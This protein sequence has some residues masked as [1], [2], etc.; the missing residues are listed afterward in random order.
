MENLNWLATTLF[1]TMV[2]IPIGVLLI[3]LQRNIWKRP[4]L[5]RRFHAVQLVRRKSLQVT[6]AHRELEWA[7]AKKSALAERVKRA[8]QALSGEAAQHGPDFS[9]VEVLIFGSVAVA[10]YI[11]ECLL[12]SWLNATFQIF[13]LSTLWWF[14]GPI[15]ALV[16]I[17]VMHGVLYV[18]MSDA[19]RPTV[20]VRRAGICVVL[21]GIVVVL[22]LW[23]ALGGRGLDFT[24]DSLMAWIIAHGFVILACSLSLLA[25]L[26][27][28]LALEAGRDWWRVSSLSVM[29][30]DVDLY[31]QHIDKLESL[32]RAS[33]DSTNPTPPLAKTNG[34]DSGDLK[35]GFQPALGTALTLVLGFVAALTFTTNG[36]HATKTA[37][38]VPSWVMVDDGRPPT[39]CEIAVDVSKSI[40]VDQVRHVAKTAASFVPQLIDSNQCQ[41]VRV[42]AFSGD[43]PFQRVREFRVPL[44]SVEEPICLDAE[45]EEKDN[46]VGFLYPQVRE[47]ELRKAEERCRTKRAEAKKQAIARRTKVISEIADAVENLANE[48]VVGTCTA[49]YQA[50]ARAVLR[51]R[52]AVVISDA[53]NDCGWYRRPD[54]E[55]LQID[56]GGT[57]SLLFLLV[58]SAEERSRGAQD[59]LTRGS[60][61]QDIFPGATVRL[62]N[63][64]TMWS[65]WEAQRSGAGASGPQ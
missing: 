9:A 63:E 36:A 7:R 56:V 38:E 15:L 23:M 33:E 47:K 3:V 1:V 42:S 5:A 39:G 61:L 37:T 21:T 55:P 41:T 44:S 58:Q 52:V 29:E 27:A 18:A 8:Q 45:G 62:L 6:E 48:N 31:S 60:G 22:A 19:I 28:V 2:V 10:L 4:D 30:Q 26:F 14:L 50:A 13:G 53:D 65:F 20:I 35:D 32:V 25:A 11:A 34:A 51:S 12:F 64:A 17:G 57:H 16:M 54:G 40:G 49:V 46:G 24:D 59:A 43:A